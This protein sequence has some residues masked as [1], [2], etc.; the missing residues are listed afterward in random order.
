MNLLLNELEIFIWT[1]N[2]IIEKILGIPLYN[3]YIYFS[4]RS[5]RGLIV[6]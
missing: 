1:Y 2:D 4:Y 6:T 5:V 3:D